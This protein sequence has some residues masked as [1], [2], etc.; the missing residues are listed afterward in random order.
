M[1]RWSHGTGLPNRNRT[2]SSTDPSPTTETPNP[3]RLL[4]RVRTAIRVLH[5]SPLT[6]K[7]YVSWIK[8]FTF[9]FD[10]RHPKEMGEAQVSAYISH[11]ATAKGV[12]Y[13]FQD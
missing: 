4:D 2:L 8:R 11:L 10:K 9:F 13:P 5:Y 3:P 1:I 6:E 7:A 12:H